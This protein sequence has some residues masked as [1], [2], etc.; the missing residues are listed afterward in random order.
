MK[1]W[2]SKRLL[3]AASALALLVC[4]WAAVAVGAL[5]YE[6]SGTQWVMIVTFA[7][8]ATEV[9]LYI[10]AAL[11]GIEALQRARNWLRFWRER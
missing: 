6:P 5:V 7:A 11:L 2:W 8:V 4:G 9:A 1:G 3:L 10:G